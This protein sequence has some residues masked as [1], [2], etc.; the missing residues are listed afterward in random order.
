MS[1]IIENEKGKVL[2]F[3]YALDEMIGGKFILADIKISKILK[4]IADSESLYNLFAKNLVDFNFRQ[5][6]KD[7]ILDKKVNGA[8]IELPEEKEKIIAYVFHLFVEVDNK[9]LDL[10]NFI[11][12]YFFNPD[13]YNFSYANFS[14]NILFPFKKAIVDSLELSDIDG[15]LATK[16]ENLEEEGEEMEE[17]MKM[18]GNEN[19]K[20]L[21][22]KLMVS[23]SDL[24]SAVL[25]ERKIKMEQKEEVYIIVSALNE[26]IKLQNIK[27]INALIIPLE[28]VLKKNKNV[29]SYYNIVQ[30]DLCEIYDALQ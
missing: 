13:G 12:E 5:E 8:L 18:G 29:R 4:C 7:S 6:F 3:F 27:I 15:E 25:N 17:E 28:Y 2:E 26:A 20:M 23:L 24:Y 22:A 19:I 14:R 21:Y 11:N 10:Q 1:A 30:D 16:E 9:K